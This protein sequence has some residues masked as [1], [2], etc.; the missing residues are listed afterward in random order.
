MSALMDIWHAIQAIVTTADYY[1][2]G[3]AVLIIIIA[4]FL[5][6]SIKGVVPVTLVALLAFVVVKFVLAL[7]I[8]GAHDVEA[9]AT[10]DWKAFVDLKMLTLLAYAL[11]FGV[12]IGVVNVIRSAVR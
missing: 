8:G 4:G 2:L 7:T 3:A 11:V 10:A 9:L 6:E 12:L 1:T 5:M